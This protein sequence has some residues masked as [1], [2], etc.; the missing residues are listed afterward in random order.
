MATISIAIYSSK[1]WGYHIY[2]MGEILASWPTGA[3]YGGG[4]G[5][6]GW[7]EDGLH[8]AYHVL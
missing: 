6:M 8:N 3:G 7:V 5:G 4:V 1:K 2:F